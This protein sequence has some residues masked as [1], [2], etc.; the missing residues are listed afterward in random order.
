M[1][2]VQKKQEQPEHI[3]GGDDIILETVNHHRVNIVTV[4]RIEFEQRKTGIGFAEGE[5]GK[6]ISDEHQHDQSAYNHVTRRE[7][8]FDV[9]LV[10]VRL[11][12]RAAISDG[13]T[14]RHVDVDDDGDEQKDANCPEQ[15]SKGAEMLGISVDPIGAEKDLEIA[16]QMSDD[17]KNEDDAGNGDDHFLADRRVI[18]GGDGVHKLSAAQ[19][20]CELRV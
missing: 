8:R 1:A 6:V 11:G 15:R 18:K 4:E 9:F 17:E 13:K 20:R 14:D 5:M 16:E 2:Q 3:K 10:A 19:F 12:T 7:S